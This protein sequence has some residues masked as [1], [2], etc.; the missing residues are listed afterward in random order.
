ME[1]VIKQF[2]EKILR[3]LEFKYNNEDPKI[4]N[5]LIENHILKKWNLLEFY[6]LY[7]GSNIYPKERIENI[8]NYLF[9]IKQQLYY[10]L[11]V[12][13]GLYNHLIYNKGYDNNVFNFPHIQLTKLSLDQNIIS[14]SRILWERFMNFI[15]YLET[16][17]E[18]ENK[19]SGSKS[20]KRV[21][22]DFIEN[23]RWKFLSQYKPYIEWYDNKLRTPEFHKLSILRKSFLLNLNID[24][25]KMNGIIN[26]FLNIWGNILNIIQG[27]EPTSRFWGS[28][29]KDLS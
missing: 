3:A 10:L 18:L 13:L 23:N 26:I 14:K 27:K 5:S 16:G 8:I 12:D 24:T 6:K 7:I 25:N 15:Y 4:R 20:K 19:V 29:L 22:F 11:E 1:E 9:D 2:E 28:F 21:F 17:E